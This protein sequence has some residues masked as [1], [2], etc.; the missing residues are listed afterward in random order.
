L[1]IGASTGGVVAIVTCFGGLYLQLKT[2]KIQQLTVQKVDQNTQVTEE[3]RL[4]QSLGQTAVI[5]KV[6]ESKQISAA[7][8]AKIDAVVAKVAGV[9][10]K[11]DTVA[12]SA[13]ASIERVA[14]A[15]LAEGIAVGHV[16]GI[17]A[18]QQRIAGMTQQFK[19]LAETGEGG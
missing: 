8:T 13:S 19:A 14:A 3:A 18:E 11:I 9:D 7:N 10:A 16:Q 1:V 4:A 5:A 15:K 17:V 2:L 6:N 12:E